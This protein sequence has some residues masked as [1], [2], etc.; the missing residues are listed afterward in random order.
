M[1]HF[2]PGAKGGAMFARHTEAPTNRRGDRLLW[3]AGREPALDDGSPYDPSRPRL[4]LADAPA[5]GPPS[6]PSGLRLLL[7]DGPHAVLVLRE[8]GEIIGANG[9]PEGVFAAPP[10]SL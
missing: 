2:N 6:G 8:G 1:S 3:A 5:A 9:L 10:G 4:L 7:D